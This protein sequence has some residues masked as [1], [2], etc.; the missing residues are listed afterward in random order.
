[1][2]ARPVLALFPEL[3]RSAFS[4][5]FAFVRLTPTR[6]L[7]HFVCFIPRVFASKRRL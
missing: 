2:N 7:S 6:A 1:M 4:S 3:I 5:R